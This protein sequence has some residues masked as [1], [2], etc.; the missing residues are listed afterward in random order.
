MEVIATP[1]N[2]AAR[3]LGIGRTSIYKLIGEGKLTTLKIGRRTLVR[4]DSI[5]A[6]VEAA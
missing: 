4:A 1:I 3:S 2:D 5:R 6:L